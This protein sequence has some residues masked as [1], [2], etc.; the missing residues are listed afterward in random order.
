MLTQRIE[1]LKKITNI[2]VIKIIDDKA[3][4][5][6]FLDF[7]GDNEYTL[8]NYDWYIIEAIKKGK[9]KIKTANGLFS[10]RDDI[11]E[12]YNHQIPLGEE[13]IDFNIENGYY[14]KDSDCN[15][16]LNIHEFEI[17][18][19]NAN[20][21]KYNPYRLFTFKYKEPIFYTNIDEVVNE[22]FK[23]QIIK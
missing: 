18:I 6:K 12:V 9:N 8:L 20:F 4:K 15:N 21:E 17:I 5:I 13:Y 22:L 11:R 23:E 14:D 16:R 19:A 3:A 10:L 7:T 1:E 2:E